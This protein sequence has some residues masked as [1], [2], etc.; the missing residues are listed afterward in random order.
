MAAKKKP[1]MRPPVDSGKPKSSD[2]TVSRTD[3]SGYQGFGANKPLQGFV[4]KYTPTQPKGTPFKERSKSSPGEKKVAP[5]QAPSP[6]KPEP[7]KPSPS[8]TVPKSVKKKK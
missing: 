7:K 8:T 4:G 5:K 3:A 1:T 6:K 2:K